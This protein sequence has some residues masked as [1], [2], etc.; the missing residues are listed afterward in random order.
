MAV[1]FSYSIRNLWT[2][3]ITSMLTAAGMALVTFVFAA[4]LMLAEGLEKT[5][6]DTGS[7][8]NVIVL[9]G[10]AETE[11]SSVIDRESAQVIA[12]QPETA[13]GPQGDSLAAMETLVLV[14]LPKATTGTP[15]NVVV[16]GVGPRSMDLRPRLNIIA[17]RNIRPGSREVIA[18]RSAAKSI[19]G[20][21]I[22][23]TLKFA[24]SEWKIVG[25]FDSGGSAFD[26]E[27][28]ADSDQLMSAFRRNSFSAV[29]M[30][31]PGREPFQD[32]KRRLE[33]DPRLS[34]QVQREVDFYRGQSEVMAAFIR[35]L[36]LAMTL[37]FSVGA[38]LGAMVTMYTAVANRTHE[39]GTLRALGFPRTGVLLAFL[40]ESAL[41]GLFG[42]SIGVL[43][44]ST[45]QLI[46]ISTMNWETFSELAF[47]FTL[48]APIA[49]YSLAFSLS[50]GLLGGF[51]PA[52]RAAHLKI[53]DALRES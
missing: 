5:L 8:E 33:S 38:I 30:K 48:T 45:L 3:K 25:L 26:S 24:L 39:I 2:R 34:V 31:V 44:G 32:L 40:T 27:V 49:A 22:G 51:L 21:S 17:G 37:F 42:G 1:P 23:S 35:I 16:R 12:V 9:R 43:A 41:L 53:V 36:G 47:G 13:Q 7:P 52:W 29:V 50:M 20:G 11:V 14:T 15:T 10:S 28:W 18:G 19:Q 46:T 6:V 4:V